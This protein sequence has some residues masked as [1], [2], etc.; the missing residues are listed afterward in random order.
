MSPQALLAAV[1]ALAVLLAWVRLLLRQRHSPSRAWRLA[2]LLLLQPA[3]AALLYFTLMPPLLRT[4][5]G[6]MTVLAAGATRAQLAA[7]AQ[8]DVLVALPEAPAL[9]GAEPAPDL[10]TALRRHPDTARLRV[11]GAGLDARDR[12]AARGLALAFE[13][14]PLPRGLVR[15]DAPAR[16]AAGAGFHVAGQAHD[17]ADGEARLLDPAGQVVDAMRVDEGGAFRL[18]GAARA[19]GPVLFSLLVLD[20]A[21]REVEAA[22]VPLW[23]ADDQAPRVLLLAGAPNPEFR[24]L[25]RWATDAGVSLHADAGVGGGVGLG[26]GPAP[27]TAEALAA[28]DLVVLDERVWAALGEAR[29]AA[30]LQA[31]S[32]G[33]GV[34]LHTNA[35]LPGTVRRQLEA[36]GLES[37]ADA[38]TAPVRL[39]A[40]GDAGML[41]ARLGPGSADAPFDPALADE[42]PPELTRRALRPVAADAVPLLHDAAGTPF[43]WWRAEGRGRIGL[44]TLT[45]SYRLA[46]AGRADL[47]AELWSAAFAVLARPN[48]NASPQFEAAPR[49]G[50]R[51]ATC[52]LEEE[53][54]QALAPDGAIVAVL[55]DPATG[56]A[57]C[58]AYWP[59]APG[60]HVLRSGDA[61]WP[62][63]VR[64]ANA[65]PGI[66]A[67]AL[68]EETLRLVGEGAPGEVKTA[69][70]PLRRGPSWPWFLGWLLA[71]GALW[72]L[73]RSRLERD[74]PHRRARAGG[75]P[76]T[77]DG[78]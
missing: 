75:H 77:S 37:S 64:A 16:V 67:A 30:L 24:Q 39:P 14:P 7:H 26:D 29:R 74:P 70:G 58:A 59:Q 10:A 19:S 50:R 44:W 63:H 2:L 21:G 27:T 1:L 22:E 51:T 43:A 18:A 47:H 48:A 61:A 11:V 53:G 23:V 46:L 13:P 4:E 49:V 57:R 20:A 56:P 66:E 68:R 71:A 3:C 72:W 8:G 73:E 31:L 9:G 52:G 40:P 6:T 38:S 34:L 62:L 28:F 41:R 78:D 54:V 69:A 32:G 35:A 17:L 5:A 15:L 36:F 45:D 60:W 33:T 12:D 65:M 76:A 55:V 42:A 25:R